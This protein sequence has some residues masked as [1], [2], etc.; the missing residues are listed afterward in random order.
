MFRLVTKWFFYH[1]YLK[2]LWS[3]NAVTY[4]DLILAHNIMDVMCTSQGRHLLFNYDIIFN[5]SYRCIHSCMSE[6]YHNVLCHPG[7]TRTLLNIVQHFNLKGLWNAVHDICFKCHTCQFLLKHCKR[8]YGK[9]PAK[10][11]ETRPLDT[12]CITLIRKY[13]MTPNKGGRKYSMKG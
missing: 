2:L 12:L 8:T 6:W 9:L 7:E 13:R 4:Y 5:W 10:E 1:A 11:I 3:C